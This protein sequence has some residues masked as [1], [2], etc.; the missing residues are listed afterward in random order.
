MRKLLLAAAPIAL[1]ALAIAAPDRPYAQPADPAIEQI[2]GAPPAEPDGHPRHGHDKDHGRGPHAGGLF[3]SPSGEPF[4]GGDGLAAWFAQADADHDGQISQA[5][6]QADALR[7]FKLYDENGD[8]V[9]DGFEIQDYERKRAPEITAILTPGEA[10][11]PGGDAGGRHGG[12][13]RGGDDPGADSSGGGRQPGPRAGRDGAARFSLL[14]EPEPL[15][16][17]DAD[18]DGKVSLAEWMRQ[19][20]HRF[21]ELDK[22]HAGR[23]TL[24]ELRPQKKK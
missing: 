11:A 23:L 6:F 24:D 3:I 12:R 17:A 14:N 7:A 21:A 13:R 18:V 16:A 1:A 4:R 5:E 2:P 9:V 22:K 19:T 8:G 15:L 10:G 20:D